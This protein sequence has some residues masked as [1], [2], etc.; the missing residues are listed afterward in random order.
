MLSVLRANNIATGATP[1]PILT[2]EALIAADPEVVLLA[3]VVLFKVEPA[4][5]AQR[6]GWAQVSA[7]RNNRVHAID[8]DVASRPGPRVIDAL[9]LMAAALYP[10]R[11]PPRGEPAY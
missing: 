10:E 3:D 11:F 6:P 2:A 7:V 5:V 8:P 1:F 4:S 9:E